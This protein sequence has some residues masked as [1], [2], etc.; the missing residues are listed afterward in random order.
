MTALSL[1]LDG[2]PAREREHQ[3]LR[4]MVALA[5]GT[6]RA[7]DVTSSADLRQLASLACLAR[8]RGPEDRRLTEFARAERTRLAGEDPVTISEAADPL[9]AL[10]GARWSLDAGKVR[11][12]LPAYLATEALQAS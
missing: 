8:G 9:Q 3:I 7:Q 2:L 5:L 12:E 4:A 10:W 6:V 1:D 11:S